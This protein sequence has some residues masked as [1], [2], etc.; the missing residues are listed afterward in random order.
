MV[1][2][3]SCPQTMPVIRKQDKGINRQRMVCHD[4]AKHLSEQRHVVG[5]AYNV[6]ALVGDR[7]EKVGASR[8]CCSAVLHGMESRVQ[9]RSG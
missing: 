9:G 4:R 3:G 2:L 7:R 8:E 6:A 5:F 1:C